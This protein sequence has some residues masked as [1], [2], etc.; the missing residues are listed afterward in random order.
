[1]YSMDNLEMRL[2][3]IRNKVNILADYKIKKA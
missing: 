2:L 1:M 3:R